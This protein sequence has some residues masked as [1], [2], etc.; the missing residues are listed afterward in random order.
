[1]IHHDGTPVVDR[2]RRAGAAH[3]NAAQQPTWSD[4]PDYD[5]SRAT[6]GS[7]PALV[8]VAEVDELRRALA[9]VAAGHA[10]VLQIGDCA[11]S[12]HETDEAHVRAKLALLHR[13]SD[14][15]AADSGQ[16]VVRIGRLGGQF[17]K[18]R[19]RPVE[20]VGERTLPAFRG[21]LVNS[22]E[23]SD[24]ARRHD[25]RRMVR[26]Y[27]LSERVLAVVRADRAC[28]A[29]D[30]PAGPWASHD[31][32]VMDYETALVRDI[33]GRR[34][35]TSTH[36]PWIGD[37]TRDPGS[38]HVALLS[39][40]DNPVACKIGP[41][42]TPASVA[43]L[44][45]RLDPERVPGRLT[46]IARLGVDDVED[47]LPPIVAAVRRRGHPVV[48]LSDP[49][50][51]NTFT[52]GDGLKTRRLADLVEEA[53]RFRRVVRRAGAH[54]GGL[55]LE[56]ATADVTECLGGAVTD[57]ARVPLR[58]TT[59]CDPRLNPDQAAELVRRWSRS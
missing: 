54:P 16:E 30:F 32:L 33:E 4:H 45:G 42:A 20:R 23:P 26:A 35:L 14:A 49:M 2:R 8:G 29:E 25:P 47:L 15:L 1:M 22:E 48:W 53:V 31:A 37:R 43:A 59:L 50:H 5:T 6:L 46:L 51:G 52:L 27:E 18:P 36:L 56:T 13:L 41:S 12:F 44:C 3:W 11:E 38:A 9:A 58:Y 19:S 34:V 17:A 55:H 21:H 7:A 24:E 28:R 40:V 39:A 10:Q 57:A